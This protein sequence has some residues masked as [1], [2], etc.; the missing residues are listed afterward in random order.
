MSLNKRPT[1]EPS[2]QYECTAI[3]E[4]GTE[5]TVVPTEWGFAHKKVEDIEESAMHY[6]YDEAGFDKAP[7]KITSIKKIGS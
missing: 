6:F 7:F 5:K 4:W 1:G 2:P 3:G